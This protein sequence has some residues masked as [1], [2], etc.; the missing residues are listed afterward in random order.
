MRFGAWNRPK[1]SPRMTNL[2]AR[3]RAVSP[4]P[5][6][7]REARPPTISRQ[8]LLSTGRFPQ[9]SARYPPT[10][11]TA[12]LVRAKTPKQQARLTG[13]VPENLL[14]EK[15]QQKKGPH[16]RGEGQDHRQRPGHEGPTS[17]QFAVEQGEGVEALQEDQDQEQPQPQ[18][19]ETLGQAVT[20]TRFPQPGQG[21]DQ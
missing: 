7:T 3:P 15:G 20:P 6:N 9:R 11:A 18:G 2:T 4:G 14:Q 10:P 16:Y 17:P 21:Q 13:G 5:A 12:A 1:P 19:Q 8:P